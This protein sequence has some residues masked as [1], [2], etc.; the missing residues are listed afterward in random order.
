MA[1]VVQ[2]VRGPVPP[3]ELG[4][5]LPHEHLICDF[6]PVSGQ[7]NQ[8]LNDRAL[9]IDELAPA[10]AAGLGCLVEV[11][12]PDLGRD[13]EALRAI[14][15]AADLHV[16]MSTGWYRGSFYP[17]H[18]AET[19]TA[20]LAE[21]M[22]A[23]LVDGVPL[24]DGSRIRAGIIGEIGVDGAHVAPAEERVLRA[25]ARAA[26]RTGA[27]LSTHTGVYPV[28]EAQLAL[29]LEEGMDPSRI[30]IGHADMCLDL[31]YHRRM[32]R[33]GAYL[34]YDTIGREHLNPDARRLDALLR[35]LDEGWGPQLM[36][37]SD[38][39]FRSDLVA[40]GGVGY[41]H[42][43]ATFVPRLLESGVPGELV[44]LM[45]VENPRRFL[46]W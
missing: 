32:L 23:E 44:D 19:P 11:T 33:A 34:Q 38:R 25:G 21:T 31:D 12:P 36:L 41:A 10:V 35:L 26:V 29:L 16:V 42:V 3:E 5:V 8:V 1:P 14:S 46:A 2:T 27:P 39:C 4:L 13:P 45:T 22:V 20:V 37:S 43:L 17:P 18:I 30:A 40:F 6:M 7:L 9:A 24:P 28:G 15:V